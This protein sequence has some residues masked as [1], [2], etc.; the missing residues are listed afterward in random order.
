MTNCNSIENSDALVQFCMNPPISTNARFLTL[1]FT[2]QLKR[3]PRKKYCCL[4]LDI[5]EWGKVGLSNTKKHCTYP[6]NCK[7]STLVELVH[8]VSIYTAVNYSSMSND[9]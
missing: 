2:R 5:K 9:N 4:I 3:S 7:K 1:L 8:A 6:L